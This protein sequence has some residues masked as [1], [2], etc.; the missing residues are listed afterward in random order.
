[1]N[2]SK[3]SHVHVH[4]QCICAPKYVH[5]KL[6]TKFLVLL[7]NIDRKTTE[8]DRERERVKQ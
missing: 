7:K 2:N 4:V 1:M 3:N 5:N 8:R 6:H